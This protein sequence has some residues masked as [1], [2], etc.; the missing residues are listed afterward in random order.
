M[1]INISHCRMAIVRSSYS[2]RQLY[3]VVFDQF[4]AHL[5][6]RRRTYPLFSQPNLDFVVRALRLNKPSRRGESR[7]EF[8]LFILFSLS[9]ILVLT[10]LPLHFGPN[11]DKAIDVEPLFTTIFPSPC[12]VSSVLYASY[13][14]DTFANA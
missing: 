10:L 3:L 11:I 7:D 6:R 5:A 1:T 8:S 2:S 4:S 12:Q 9:S 14:V 13:K